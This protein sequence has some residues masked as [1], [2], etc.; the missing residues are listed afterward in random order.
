MSWTGLCADCGPEIMATNVLSLHH[1]SGPEFHRWR[2]A[3]AACV[4]GV[5]PEELR[6]QWPSR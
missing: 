6:D 3:M 5:L 4:G 2:R 1:K